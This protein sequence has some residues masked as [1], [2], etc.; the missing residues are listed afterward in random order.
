[1]APTRPK[2]VR[3]MPTMRVPLMPSRKGSAARSA[4]SAALEIQA[5]FFAG[6]E[7]GSPCAPTAGWPGFH[8]CPTPIGEDAKAA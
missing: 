5:L 7:A 1:M 3:A 8:C 6:D 2:A 4:R